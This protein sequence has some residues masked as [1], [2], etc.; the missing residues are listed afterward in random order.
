M[1]LVVSDAGREEVDAAIVEQGHPGRLIGHLLVDVLPQERGEPSGGWGRRQRVVGAAAG[2]L[3]L[4]VCSVAALELRSGAGVSVALGDNAV[5][6]LDGGG[7][8]VAQT[9]FADPPGGVAVGLG[10]T[11]VTD[12]AGDAL[13]AMD[14]TTSK[15]AGPP[16]PIGSVPTGVA[17]AGGRVW[18]VDTG[19]R[20]VA[21]YDPRSGRVLKRFAIGNGA[22]PIAAGGG[23]VWVVNSA[24]G[25]AQ[26]IDTRFGRVSRP[27]AVGAAPSAIAVGGGG[28]WVTDEADGLLAR[29]NPQTLQVTQV[30]V[31]RTPAAAGGRSRSNRTR[32]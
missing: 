16:I 10:Q 14:S 13:R 22:G 6:R 32:W 25:T 29:I 24:D 21:E 1:V 5:G 15:P 18:V 4:A 31:G 12:P 2:V 23:A 26:R 7:R 3:V 11:W 19:D 30:P 9:D 28:V 27:I 20:R 17:V 8:V